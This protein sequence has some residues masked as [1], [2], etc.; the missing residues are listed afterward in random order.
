M[1]IGY[2]Q[3][4]FD[5]ARNM[6]NAVLIQEH[7]TWHGYALEDL[8]AMTKSMSGRV[9]IDNYKRYR[10]HQIVALI[11]WREIVRRAGGLE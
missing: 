5:G 8:K 1:A 6:S 4:H 3:C 9:N 2:L 11:Y 7:G 10:I